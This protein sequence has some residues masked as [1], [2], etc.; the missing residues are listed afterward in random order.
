MSPSPRSKRVTQLDVLVP[1]TP[2]SLAK[3]CDALR[4]AEVNISAISCTEG[5]PSSVL[6]LVV[7]DI[8]TAKVAVEHLGKVSTSE[9]LAFHMKDKPGAIAAV[10]RRLAGASINIRNIYA[11]THG[12]Q[13]KDAMVYVEVNGEID[14][15]E[16]L[17]STS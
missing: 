5:H 10:A 1:N 2:W 6:H 17:F 4:G 16:Q 3:V 13:G 15:A 7:S 8:E 11:T 12:R 9:V 14:R